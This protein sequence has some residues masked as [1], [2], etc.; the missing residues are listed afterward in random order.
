[1]MKYAH[2]A[3]F[4]CDPTKRG[5]PEDVKKKGI[6]YPIGSKTSENK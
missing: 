2:P 1:M 3:L 6:V 5:S 4:K